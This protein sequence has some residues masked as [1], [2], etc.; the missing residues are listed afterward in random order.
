MAGQH[1][2]IIQSRTTGAVKVGRSDDPDRRLRQLQTGCPHTL[3]VIL[4]MPNGG[5]REVS[6][7]HAMRA[8]RTRHSTGGEWFAESG[9]GDV[10]II[11]W[12]HA[13]PWYMADPD[14]W[15]RP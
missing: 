10:P 3:K 5:V 1:L 4:V 12:E 2:Y 6:V 14:W 11:V 8:H 15:R 7:H 9:L 13:L